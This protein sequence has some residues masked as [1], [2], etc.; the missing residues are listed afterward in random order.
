MQSA[1]PF[2]ASQLRFEPSSTAVIKLAQSP[3]IAA[4][5]LVLDSVSSLNVQL[6]RQIS[7]TVT[8]RNGRRTLA[9]HWTCSVRTVGTV[10]APTAERCRIKVHFRRRARSRAR[11]FEDRR[12]FEFSGSYFHLEKKVHL[13]IQ[14]FARPLRNGDDDLCSLRLFW[15]R[16]R[17]GSSAPGSRCL[18]IGREPPLSAESHT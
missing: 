9:S 18:F 1:Q 8:A 7:E 13:R 14:V 10:R 11:P 17:F 5:S 4:D 3:L 12:D 16:L 15:L 2:K 6:M